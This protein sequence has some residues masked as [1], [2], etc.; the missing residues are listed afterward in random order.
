MEFFGYL[1]FRAKTIK[2]E[3][4]VNEELTAEEWKR[5]FEK[6][7]EKNAKLRSK[8]AQYEIGAIPAPQKGSSLLSFND[9]FKISNVL[10][11][12]QR[13]TVIESRRLSEYRCYAPMVLRASRKQV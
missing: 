2:N 12:L 8:L 10:S 11:C 6:E 5:R 7:K 3:I 9:L 1:G 4:H 13:G